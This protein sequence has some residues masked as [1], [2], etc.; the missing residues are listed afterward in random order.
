MS[1]TNN[2]YDRKETIG[3]AKDDGSTAGGGGGDL[4][5]WGLDRKSKLNKLL[6]AS[7]TNA[8][9]FDISSAF[10]DAQGYDT[11]WATQEQ[12]HSKDDNSTAGGGGG[13]IGVWQLPRQD[14]ISR[15][16]GAAFTN[17]S[18]FEIPN[19]FVD[20]QGYQSDWTDQEQSHGV[21]ATGTPLATDGGALAGE[22]SIEAGD[23][24]AVSKDV[25]DVFT[26]SAAPPGGVTAGPDA[27][28]ASYAFRFEPFVQ[29][30]DFFEEDIGNEYDAG[31]FR[32]G[33]IDGTVTD[34]NGDPVA[35]E[36]LTAPGGSTSTSADG[37]YKIS[38]PGGTSVDLTS[39]GG[40]VT[41]SAIPSGGS[42]VSIDYQYAGVLALTSLPDGTSIPNAPVEIDTEE[43]SVRT[44]RAG[45]YQYVKVPPE[46][47]VTVEYLNSFEE[48]FTAGTEGSG[49]QAEL[50][51]G[52]GCKGV[53]KSERGNKIHN[54]DLFMDIEGEPVSYSRDDGQYAIGVV[55]PGDLTCVCSEKD[56]RYERADEQVNLTRGDVVEIEFELVDSR[57]I[58]NFG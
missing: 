50:S 17:E 48:T 38:A 16:G 25:S 40:E 35:N 1:F 36:S 26:L 53:I 2:G 23:D 5:V 57:N 55:N 46:T 33:S 13:V 22:A 45:E 24:V 32:Y 52:A 4:E 56:R 3:N 11:D 29:A 21:S 34:Y 6:K 7:I 58:G 14:K 9:S 31:V 30:I 49:I 43:G 41:K 54:V 20:S 47:D 10:V 15:L 28:T 39:L 18:S 19:G 42:T 37:T 8:S 51:L 12:A 27:D 44:D